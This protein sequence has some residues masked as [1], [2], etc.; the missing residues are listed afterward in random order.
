M[1]DEKEVV[2]RWIL[3]LGTRVGKMIL[4]S[5]LR[6]GDAGLGLGATPCTSSL[7]MLSL[8]CG[9]IMTTGNL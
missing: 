7:E 5:S 9:Q 1:G 8:G 3:G 4:P 2:K 6:D